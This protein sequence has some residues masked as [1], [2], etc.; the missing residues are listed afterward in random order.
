ME[1]EYLWD[2]FINNKDNWIGAL[3]NLGN[4]PTI[5]FILSKDFYHEHMCVMEQCC[6]EFTDF[7][8]V[9]TLYYRRQLVDMIALYA[10][11]GYLIMHIVWL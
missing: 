3:P 9:Y 4:V 5:G 1:L 10:L 7:I 2:K 11:Y 8:Q 6:F